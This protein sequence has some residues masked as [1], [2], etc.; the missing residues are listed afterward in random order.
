MVPEPALQSVD[1]SV[2]RNRKDGIV[3]MGKA[4]PPGVDATATTAVDT[5]A[6][7]SRSTSRVARV[8][9]AS[10]TIVSIAST[11]ISRVARSGSR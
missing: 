10:G 7:A 8:R 6:D 9:T 3:V 1:V 4:P 11:G 5:P 2:E